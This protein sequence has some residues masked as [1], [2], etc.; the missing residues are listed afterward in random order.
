MALMADD[1][2]LP[3]MRSIDTA[4]A[5]VVVRPAVPAD[6]DDL[7]RLAELDGASPLAGDVVLAERDG[8]P[9]AALALAD[10]RVVADPFEPTAADVALLRTR[11]RSAGGPGRARRRTLALRRRRLA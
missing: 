1:W 4:S 11:A 9:L 7:T 2:H 8:R 3:P 6:H 10:G 5:A